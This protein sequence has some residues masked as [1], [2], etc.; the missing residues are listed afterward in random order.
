MIE[1]YA[2]EIEIRGNCLWQRIGEYEILSPPLPPKDKFLNGGVKKKKDQ[3][4]GLVSDDANLYTVIPTPDRWNSMSEDE[5]NEWEDQE[6]E[7]RDN[8]VWFY[9]NGQ[10]TWITGVHYYFLNYYYIKGEKPEYRDADRTFF[11]VWDYCVKHPKCFGM[12]YITRRQ[13][14]KCLA[15]G[16]KVRMFDGSLKNVEDIEVGEQVMGIDSN[17]RNVLSVHS[18]IDEMYEI[19]QNRGMNYVVNSQHTISL[20]RNLSKYR[21]FTRLDGRERYRSY[22]QYDEIANIPLPELRLKSPKFFNSFSGFRKGF[23][24]P[25]KPVRLDPYFLGCWLGDGSATKA[26]ITTPEPE[27]KDLVYKTAAQYGLS[28]N[29]NYN[30]NKTC[31]TYIITGGL[32]SGGRTNQIQKDFRHYGLFEEKHIPD[33]FLRNSRENRMELLAGIIDTDGYHAKGFYEV[34]QKGERLSRDIVELARSLGFHCSIR[35]T[36]KGIKSTGFSGEYYRIGICGEIDTIPLKVPRKRTQLKPTK[37]KQL[38]HI[39]A[40]NPVGLGEYF[41][42]ELDGDHLFLLEDGTVTHNSFKG[43]NIALEYASRTANKHVG[44]QS[45]TEEDAEDLF[46]RAVVESW[47]KLPAYFSPKFSNSASLEIKQIKFEAPSIKG[48]GSRREGGGAVQEAGLNTYIDYAASL[49]GAYDGDPKMGFYLHDELGKKQLQDPLK[50]WSIVRK[51]FKQ[52][53]VLIAKSFH[54]SSVG[55]EI[56]EKGVERI[57]KFWD[58]SNPNKLLDNGETES[59]LFRLFSPNYVGYVWDEYGMDCKEESI[60]EFKARR[61]AH[62]RSGDTTDLLGEKRANPFTIDEALLP[63]SSGGVYNQLILS[64]SVQ[65]IDYHN[66]ECH[67]YENIPQ[68]YRLKWENPETK[69]KVIAEQYDSKTGKDKSLYRFEFSWL[70]PDSTMMNRV[71]AQGTVITPFGMQ[72]RFIPKNSVNF[73]VAVDPVDHFAVVDEVRASKFSANG[74]WKYDPINEQKADLPDYWPS[75]SFIFRYVQRIKNEVMYED[76]VMACHLLG[77][78]IL[79]ENNKP[80]IGTY[81]INRGYTAFLDGWEGSEKNGK[82]GIA[83]SGQAIGKYVETTEAWIEDEKNGLKSDWRRCPFKEI[84]TQWMN[85]NPKDTKKYDEAVSASYTLLS[86]L[87]YAPIV[88]EKQ[89]AEEFNFG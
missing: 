34:V 57:K 66:L 84:L 55:E 63:E 70:P 39:D 43:G 52:K 21:K 64:D 60:A 10:P 62:E 48:K 76:M 69:D 42:F 30:S 47:L 50:R 41:G 11:W 86:C 24:L 75:G 59:G 15:K 81:F 89:K 1:E 74:F 3:K 83:A 33:D 12:L 78:K 26:G 82:Y 88:Q 2:S 58:Q 25:S 18:G 28:V 16:T 13:S 32:E 61:Q 22:P 35:K 20:H 46:K 27:I 53:N 5:Q 87:R 6:W 73:G 51:I 8:G 49:V 79:Y 77:C 14:G 37:N 36:T 65:K 23:D 85:F 72:T 7:R 68:L 17:P 31:P 44:M 29:I 40:I 71:E 80:G 56:E 4:W 19:V 54:T 9:N 38:T 45:K 67:T